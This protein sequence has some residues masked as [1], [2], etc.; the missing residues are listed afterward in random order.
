LHESKNEFP[1]A[2]LSNTPTPGRSPQRSGVFLFAENSIWT[3]RD[4][5]NRPFLENL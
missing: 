3:A 5:L 4:S 1:P 2:P